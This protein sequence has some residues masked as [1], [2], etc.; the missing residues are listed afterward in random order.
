MRRP[1]GFFQC[2]GG[3]HHDRFIFG[4]VASAALYTFWPNLAVVPSG[5]LRKGLAAQGLGCAGIGVQSPER[6]T[7]MDGVPTRDGRVHFTL[8]PVEKWVVG[9]VAVAAVSAGAWQVRSTQTLI[10]QAAVTNEQ[11]R[12]LNQQM[13]D[14]PSLKLELAK[15]AVQIGQNTKDIAELRAVKGLK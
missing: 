10:I 7:A 4:A 12:I 8:G 3:Q 14:V 5:W 6:M 1:C 9:I 2:N 13:S 11:L 15:Q